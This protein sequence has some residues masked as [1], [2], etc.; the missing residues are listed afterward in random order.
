MLRTKVKWYHLFDLPLFSIVLILCL[1]G[2]AFAYSSG[3]RIGGDIDV[4]QTAYKKQIFFFLSGIGLMAI[5]SL[6]NYKK[7]AEHSILI[8][9]FCIAMLIYT[10]L[11]GK[12][13]N[14]SKRWIDLGFSTIQASEFVKILMILVIAQFLNLQRDHLKGIKPLISLF[15]LVCIPILLI[16][17][18]PDLGTA[19]VFIPVTLSMML[20]GGVNIKFFSAILLI[21]FTAIAIPISLTYGEMMNLEDNV[22]FGIISN[23]YYLAFIAIFLFS[24]AG[25]V[26]IVNLSMRNLLLY[27]IAFFSLSL[28]TGLISALIVQTFLLK[29]YQRERIMAFLNPD[30]DRRDV[31]YNVFQSQVTIGSG[32]FWGKGFAEGTQGQL[33]FLPS[34][35]TD[36]IFSVIGEETGFIGS[37]LIL[38]LLF[39]FLWRLLVIASRVKDYLGGLIVVGIASMFLFQIFINVGMTIG[40]AP[41][42]G[43][44]L[45]FLTYGGSTLW[46]SLLALG[47]VFSIEMRKFVHGQ[48]R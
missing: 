3:I 34:R 24:F 48:Y 20:V 29:D 19:L 8:Y 17:L 39:L 10:L 35:S 9:V 13:V 21:G 38:I 45:P 5:T 28:F 40:M 22:F 30:F 46:S 6:I 25:I 47:L 42:T 2:I 27:D 26:L 14:N 16:F 41:V 11:F 12:V 23:K 33:G 1:L 43:L 31:G 7:L 37:F 18:Q 44:P 32:G 15:A 36:F 4:V